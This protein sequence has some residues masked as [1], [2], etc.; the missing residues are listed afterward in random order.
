VNGHSLPQLLNAL[1]AG[2][3][4][5]VAEG[6]GVKGTSNRK[7]D[8]VA[9]LVAQAGDPAALGRMLDQ[10]SPPQRTLLERL[11]PYPG[12][13]PGTL[14]QTLAQDAGLVDPPARGDRSYLS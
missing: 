10:L 12:L 3:L 11:L 4:R 5:Q 8:L 2:A 14:V 7:S 6:R 9:A 1:S 13:L